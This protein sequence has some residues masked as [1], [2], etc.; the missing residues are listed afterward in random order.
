MDK[1]AS[2]L[3]WILRF[4]LPLLVIFGAIKLYQY[5][6]A[7]APQ[8]ARVNP[9]ERKVFVNAVT[10]QRQKKVV[11]VR[12]TGT[13]VPVERVALQ[14]R[15]AGEALELHP[16]FEPGEIIKKGEVIVSID[17]AD[18]HLAEQLAQ[19]M[20]VQAE[21]EYKLELGYQ[22]VAQHEW[23][24][25]EDKA[26]ATELE[27][28][29]TLRKP[30]L[31][32]VEAR[33]ASAKSALE[34]VR[35]D[36]ARTSVTLPFDAL[37]LERTVSMGSQVNP[38]SQLGIFVDASRFRVE[39][40]VPFDQIGWIKMPTKDAPGASV[41]ITASGGSSGNALWQGVVTG[42]APEIESRGRMARLLVEVANPLAGEVPLLL[43]SFVSVAITSRELDN[44]FVIPAL[45]VHNGEVVYVMN[46]E[47]RVV[48][49]TIVVI[50]RDQDWVVAESG[51]ENGDVL[52][53][54]DIPAAV[55]NM[56]VEQIE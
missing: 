40:T 30:H 2:I 39:V 20:L 7:T 6:L 1:R 29:L 10:M 50:W 4:T 46:A 14:A 3:L 27:K 23:E 54:S 35:L 56:R 16:N 36:L 12:A 24:M 38:Q 13:V 17:K 26:S 48:F 44:V 42:L 31:Q 43:N 53:V 9:Q 45:S 49:K 5:Q 15:V 28:E 41:Q 21:Y 32:K 11:S 34:Q 19:S 33:V 51:L 18:Y 52:I 22:E 55:P 37:V 25:I 47:S 8:Q